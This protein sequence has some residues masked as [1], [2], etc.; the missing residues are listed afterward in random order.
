MSYDKRD[1]VIIANHDISRMCCVLDQI[2]ENDLYKELIQRVDEST[3]FT[4]RKRELIVEFL[5]RYRRC[6]TMNYSKEG[7]AV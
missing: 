1:L 6:D 3:V 4:Y 5:E 7:K 2:V